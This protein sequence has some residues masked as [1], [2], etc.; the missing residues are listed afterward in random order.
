[1]TEFTAEQLETLQR[2]AD[3]ENRRER[4][5][6]M[7]S[8]EWFEALWG[9]PHMLA[10]LTTLLPKEGERLTE[11]QLMLWL[12][13]AEKTA[14]LVYGLRSDW[15]DIMCPDPSAH[16]ETEFEPAVAADG[17]VDASD[18]STSEEEAKPEAEDDPEPEPP[19]ADPAPDET[20]TQ[21]ENGGEQAERDDAPG[22]WLARRIY[23]GPLDR[24]IPEALAAA[25]GPLTKDELYEALDQKRGV[26]AKLA[27][28]VKDGTVTL[29][30]EGRYALGDGEPRRCAEEGCDTILSVYNEEDRCAV[31]EQEA[32]VA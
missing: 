1:M 32:A 2:M 25:E 9:R 27:W 19:E 5:G 12:E 17:Q 16:P 13:V 30:D 7:A 26:G 22:S 10:A 15:N 31:H 20:E 23:Q 3:Q 11:A 18:S 8:D 4:L 14:R 28:M 21:S 6:D 29:D 24:R